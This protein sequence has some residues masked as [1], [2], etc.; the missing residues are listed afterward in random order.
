MATAVMDKIKLQNKEFDALDKLIKTYKNLPAVVDDDYPE[1]R[2][3]YES[4]IRAFLEACKANG[5]S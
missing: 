3:Y 1:M 5:R 2:H 4:A